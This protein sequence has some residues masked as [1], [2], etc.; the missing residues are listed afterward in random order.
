MGSR[1]QNE[2]IGRTGTA[3]RSGLAVPAALAAMLL[4]A[5]CAGTGSP[6]GIAAAP[7]PAGA[8]VTAQAKPDPAAA[9][10]E[11]PLDEHTASAHCWMKYDSNQKMSLDQKAK[12]VD[13]CIDEML[14]RGPR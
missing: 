7:S 6:A 3:R 14:R 9:P 4:L 8:V 13:A 12:A 1:R 5:G 2:A 10:V 11:V